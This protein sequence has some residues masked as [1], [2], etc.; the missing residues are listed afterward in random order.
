[1]LKNL[2]NYD[3]PIWSIT[4]Y[5]NPVHYRRR[6]SNF[7]EFRKFLN[8]PLLVVELGF[9]GVFELC[10]EDADIVISISGD[11]ILWQKERLLNI[12][13]RNLPP[14]VRYIAWLDCDIV[15]GRKE[16]P[17]LAIEALK[18]K[19]VV[20]LFDK[21]FDIEKDASWINVDTSAMKHSGIGI[22]FLVENGE[23]KLEDF[24][25]G[26][27]RGFRRGLFGLA[28]AA[29]RDLMVR[30]GFYD[31]MI[32]GSGDRAL[33]CAAFGRF[34]DAIH[35]ARLTPARQEHYL[36][37]A[38]PFYNEVQRNVGFLEGDLF[39]YWHGEISDRRYMER[40]KDLAQI[41]FD[42]STDIVVDSDGVWEW[43]NDKKKLH[44]FV[45][46]YFYLRN[47]DGSSSSN[48]VN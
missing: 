22:A 32:L 16:W 40:H 12:A 17:Q 19:Q 21:L 34:E 28:W 48:F 42:P 7:K 3:S 13:I 46:Q 26:S 36:N 47:E 27:S 39:H 9:G 45:K 25:P 20:Q 44:D 4:S 15:L 10:K 38:R 30:H 14:H 18:R 24:R 1:M 6:L 2:I 33:A 41:D 37:W 31:A 11:S 23:W 29:H 35:A 43:S 5:Y 8:V